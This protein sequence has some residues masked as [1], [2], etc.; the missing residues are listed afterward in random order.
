M[1]NEGERMLPLIKKSAPWYNM[2]CFHGILHEIWFKERDFPTA[3]TK[4][5][6]FE[7]PR[8]TIILQKPSPWRLAWHRWWKGTHSFEEAAEGKDIT[9]WWRQSI[10]KW[11]PQGK[12]SGSA[13]PVASWRVQ[14]VPIFRVK[15]SEFKHLQWNRRAVSWIQPLAWQFGKR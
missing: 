4:G 3:C 14:R 15:M 11:N 12:A 6:V 10:N 2:A 8:F 1:V 9:W 13:G 7:P 5:F